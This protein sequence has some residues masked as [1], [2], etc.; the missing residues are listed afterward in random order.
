MDMVESLKMALR[1]LTANKLRAA[2]TMLGMIIGVSAVIALMAIGQGATASITSQIQGMG[3]NLLFVTPGTATQGGFSFG[4]G[5]APTLTLEDAQAILNE[6]P[7]VAG[8]APQANNRMQVVF[9]P[10]NTNTSVLGTTPDYQ[11]VRNS[12]VA[13]GEFFTQLNVDSRS[14]V[15]LLGSTTAETLFGEADPI[16]QQ[17]KINRVSFQ[18]I[19]VM[20]TKGSQAGGN[21]DDV[22]II[23]IT[24]LLQRLTRTRTSRG[25]LVVQSINVQVVD[26]ASMKPAVESI[27]NLLRTRHRVTQDD[28]TVRSQ[29][30]I[31]STL[32]TVTQTLTILLGSIAGISLV[33]G[34]IGIMN[35]MLVSVTERTREIGIRKA[36]GAKRSDIMIQFIIEAMVVSLM[37]GLI[38]VLLGIG[39][40]QLLSG[41]SLGGQALRTVVSTDAIFLAFGVSAAIGLFFGIYPASRAAGLDPIQALRYE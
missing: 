3:T 4:A 39:I 29:E 12:R 18:V 31:L 32:Q 33:V 19:G 13:V 38:G 24:T 25:G 1:S 11:D 22:V 8:V 28:F 41:V 9:G 16:G 14:R 2:L 20:E 27:G 35:I 36:I 37:G 21:Q 15:A 10:N 17:I 7:E 34:G 6:V 26:E 40:S 5:T 30:D 23:P